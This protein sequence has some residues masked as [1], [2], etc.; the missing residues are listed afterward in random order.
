MSMVPLDVATTVN[1][2]RIPLEIVEF[3]IDVL[4]ADDEIRRVP[5]P[6]KLFFPAVGN[7]FSSESISI[8][9]L[10]ADMYPQITTVTMLFLAG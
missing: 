5:K 10:I 7:T 8:P 2:S 1:S 3:V 9:D 6:V 4:N